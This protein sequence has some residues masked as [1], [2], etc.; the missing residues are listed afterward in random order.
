ML[1]R[2]IEKKFDEKIKLKNGLS[3]KWVA[4]GNSGVPDRIVI[5]NG[6]VIF[7]ELKTI[8]GRMSKLQE[9]QHKKIRNIYPDIFVLYGIEEVERFINDL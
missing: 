4:P 7:V 8:N 1:E 5:I 9:R 2:E 6:K 3:Y